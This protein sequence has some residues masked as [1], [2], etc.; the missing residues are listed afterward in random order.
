MALLLPP[1]HKTFHSFGSV[2]SDMDPHR[3]PLVLAFTELDLYRIYF[4]VCSLPV[5]PKVSPSGSGIY[6]S[7]AVGVVFLFLLLQERKLPFSL[8][9]EDPL[10]CFML[11]TL[12]ETEAAKMF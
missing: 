9:S 10:L 5:D 6:F 3:S 8:H 7:S 1:G 4:Q 2:T 12:R 11:S